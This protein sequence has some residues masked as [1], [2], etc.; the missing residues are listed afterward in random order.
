MRLPHRRVDRGWMFPEIMLGLVFLAWAMVRA[1]PSG[2]PELEELSPRWQAWATLLL[3]VGSIVCIATV[4][5]GW[6]VFRGR[7]GR[8]AAAYAFGLATLGFGVGS[9]AFAA[10]WDASSVWVPLSGL[11]LFIEAG[12]VRALFDLAM[13]W[14]NERRK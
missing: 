10:V 1:W 12:A 8:I 4:V 13:M 2:D 11:A 9:Y 5:A 6:R 7:E 3:L 14:R